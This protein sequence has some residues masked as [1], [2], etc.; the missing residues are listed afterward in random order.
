VLETYQC[1]DCNKDIG[2]DDAF[3]AF[4]IAVDEPAGPVRTVRLH[5]FDCLTNF[6]LK[7][8]YGPIAAK[9]NK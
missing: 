8:P 2:P 9:K 3:V 4:D 5:P 7:H 6:R 1:E